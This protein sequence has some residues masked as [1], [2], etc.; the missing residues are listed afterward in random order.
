ML[1]PAKP[2][3]GLVL[4]TEETGNGMTSWRVGKTAKEEDLNETCCV[5]PEK[6]Q[7]EGLRKE[8]VYR[9]E[10]KDVKLCV[11]IRL[12]EGSEFL[13]FRLETEWTML[14]N[15]EQGIPQ[16]RFLLPCGY[17]PEKYRYAI[18]YGILDRPPLAQD[19]PAIG[20]GCALPK[21]GGRALCMLS[22]SKYGFRGDRE[23]LSLNLLRGS[24]DPDPYPEIGHHIIRI[25][26]GVCNPARENLA[27]LAE[28][29]IHPVITRSCALRPRSEEA[30]R[31][32]FHIE[33]GILSAIKMAEEGEG[34]IVR[35]Y[36]PAGEKRSMSLSMPG[37][38]IEAYRCDFLEKPLESVVAENSEAMEY[39][40]GA[41]EVVSFRIIYG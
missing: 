6:I 28:R 20:L 11:S 14:G 30:E 10:K 16:L 25:A 3:C 7:L 17:E 34:L 8:L 38:K 26:V 9:V 23:G 37:R 18:P 27:L 31:S 21:G 22:D 33:G 13:D 1:N 32:L 39:T 35:V 15:R 12:D 4:I 2:A 19:V 41:G 40:M 36:N 29:Y 24:Y 5:R